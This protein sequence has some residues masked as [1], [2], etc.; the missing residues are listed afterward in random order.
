MRTPDDVDY[1]QFI[2]YVSLWEKW[3]DSNFVEAPWH[4]IW[5]GNI[6][7]GKAV[8]FVHLSK[9]IIIINF[10]WRNRK[11][12]NQYWSLHQTWYLKFRYSVMNAP[13]CKFKKTSICNR[14]LYLK[15][16]NVHRVRILYIHVYLAIDKNCHIYNS[17]CKT[18]TCSLESRHFE[19]APML[20]SNCLTEVAPIITDGTTSFWSSHLI[21]TC[22]IVFP[23]KLIKYFM[24]HD[25]IIKSS[26]FAKR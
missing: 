15:L 26:E 13:T 14:F 21:A 4:L 9:V 7:L 24:L 12:K 2:L 5:I 6:W 19:A 11:S 22:G 25:V 3:I 18:S 10:H 17:L 1:L 8:N 16:H 23:W 20:S